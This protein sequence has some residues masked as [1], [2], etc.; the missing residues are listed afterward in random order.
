MGKQYAWLGSIV[1][2]V[3]LV[4][5]PLSAVALVKLPLAKW[6]C[7]NILGCECPT[8]Q[9]WSFELTGPGGIAV[10]CMAA[11]TNWTGLMIT[12]AL[13]GGFEATIAPTFISICQMWWRRREQTYRNTFWLLSSPIASLVSSF[14]KQSSFFKEYWPKTDL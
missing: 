12:R 5:Q 14:F 4:V 8:L 13:V 6:I 9:Q 3:Q 7:F 2:L 11:C 10:S 1:Y